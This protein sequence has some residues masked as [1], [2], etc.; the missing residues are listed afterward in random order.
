MVEAAAGPDF[1]A[2]GLFAAARAGRR[3]V[4]LLVQAGLGAGADALRDSFGLEMPD[5][6]VALGPH[7][8]AAASVLARFG[9]DGRGVAA[10]SASGVNEVLSAK[11]GPA[12]VD[13]AAAIVDEWRAWYSDRDGDA[14]SPA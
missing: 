13:R 12:D 7:G 5:R 4:H 14:G 9:L 11:P 6:L 10:A 1:G 3:L 8:A 2:A